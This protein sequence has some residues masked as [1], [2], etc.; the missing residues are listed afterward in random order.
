[1]ASEPNPGVPTLQKTIRAL[2]MISQCNQELM[3]AANE[4]DLLAA[5]CRIIVESGGYRMA[6]V[7]LAEN[8]A[9]QSVRPVAQQGFVEGYLDTLRLTWD[10]AE[11]GRGPTG[12]AIR[13]RRPCAIQN[14]REDP[15]FVPWRDEAR[16]RGYAAA[17]GLPLMIEDGLVG[18]LTIYA[19]EPDAFDADE[20][21]LLSELAGDLAFGLR[22]LRIRAAHARA[23]D[24]LRA[25][26][27]HWQTTFNAIADGV[28]LLDADGR[29][30]KCNAAMEQFL[31]KPS[32]NIVGQHCFAIVHGAAAPIPGCPT[33]RARQSKSR[34]TM[35]L[36]IGQRMFAVT[37][38]P[39]LDPQ[40]QYRGAVHIISDITDRKRA[41]EALRESEAR[42]RTMLEQ[43]ADAVIVHDQ[44]G[45]IIDANRKACQSLGYSREELLAKSVLDIDPEA[46][47]AGKHAFWGRILAGE[48]FT[49]ES[50]HVRK[51]ATAFPVEV[52]LGSVRLPSGPAILGIV[53]DIT[54]QKK[55]R[56][57]LLQSQKMEAIALLAGGVAH[58]FRNQLT[59]VKG[60]AEMLIESGMVK[61]KGL[62]YVQQIL[63]AA[64][65]CADLSGRL[66]AFGRRQELHP[67]VVNLDLLIAD[68]SQSLARMVGE[69]VRL[70]VS[71]RGNLG[72][73]KIDAAQ[74]QQALINLVVNARDA[75]PRGGQLTIE[76]ADSDVDE[77]FAK[78][79]SDIPPGPYVLTTVSDTGIGMDQATRQRIFEPFFTTK[80]VGQGTGL[81][82]PMVYGFIRQ[83]GGH[84]SV[85]SEPGHG[86]TFKLYLPR[87]RD[88]L[89]AEIPT[90]TP[91][92]L[93]RGSET[94]LLIEDDDAIRR[95]LSHTL[96]KYGYTVLE[97]SG[98][99]EALPLGE[100]YDRPI[101]LLITDVIM[102]EMSG[103]EIAAKI[104]AAR[105]GLP[106]LFISGHTG[107]ALAN[108][109]VL[110]PDANLL[111]K[112]FSPRVLVATV[113][114]LLREKK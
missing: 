40:G 76:T 13:T 63:L 50:R 61:E 109:G 30:L 8:D 111:L 17:V 71:S 14:M 96:R 21:A 106:V 81:G 86:T 113:Q 2:R 27:H 97:A 4:P 16:N 39:L 33:L 79:H 105:P 38:D 99:R 89:T 45:R 70:S 88:D 112:P 22:T 107:G 84:V 91:A 82:L 9:A 41:A 59:V 92:A 46:I 19:V 73:V 44:A 93:P 67:A 95:L 20:I 36:P 103:P 66:L 49:F 23:E 110:S 101:D 5:L 83:S 102:P 56:G 69:D 85:Y 54:E 60:Y 31:G 15:R 62:E 104:V 87:V 24:A 10:D 58:D 43:A 53:R 48:Q 11:R 78:Q 94:I 18:A 28:A 35:E 114:K 108:R 98:A 1:M 90:Q 100:H 47:R 12:T 51:D 80:P 68:L 77:P 26:E 37:V 29:V 34:E 42:Y 74:F 25:S 32:A 72:H 52:T 64:E 75:M 65:W 3:R 57:Q 7:G 6:W 55:L